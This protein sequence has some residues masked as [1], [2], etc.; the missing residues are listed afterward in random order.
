[1]TPGQRAFLW[2]Q[3]LL[4]RVL[5]TRLMGALSRP[6][7]PLLTPLVIRCLIRFFRIDM[8]EAAEPDPAAYASV[9]AFFTR[10]LRPGVRPLAAAPALLCPCDGRVSEAGSLDGG[11]LLQAK[12]IHYSAADLLGDAALAESF[13]GGSFATLYLAPADYHRVHMPA[14]GVLEGMR[15]Q[16]GG[17][18]SVNTATVAARRGLFAR[19]ERVICHFRGAGESFVMVLVGAM[20]VGGIRTPWAGRVTPRSAEPWQMR[21]G[22]PPVCARGSEMGTFEFGSTVILLFPPQRVA[23]DPAL[24]PGRKLRMGEAIGVVQDGEQAAQ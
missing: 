7:I 10:R 8:S 16:P 14:D 19:N 17:L 23:L 22:Q 21:T 24:K 20:M 13:H 4:P 1:M 3:Y 9:N 12:G 6:A 5:L 18:F 11:R 15:Y 2:L